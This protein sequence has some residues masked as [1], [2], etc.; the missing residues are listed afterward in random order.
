MYSMTAWTEHVREYAKTHNLSYGCAM[1]E[2][3][4]KASY[5][6]KKPQKLNK[7]ETKENESMGAEE[8]T[9]EV[10]RTLHKKAEHKKKVVGLKAKMTKKQVEKE[11]LEKT[12]SI[13]ENKQMGMEDRDVPAP[14]SRTPVASPAPAS[15]PAKKK[16]GRPK[17]YASAEEAKE[18]KKVKTIESNKRKAQ[19]KKAGK[20]PAPAKKEPNALKFD[21]DY[22]VE[23]L[24]DDKL[25]KVKQLIRK[26]KYV[27]KHFDN[28]Y[29]SNM[30]TNWRRGQKP[31]LATDGEDYGLPDKY[32]IDT[33][34]QVEMERDG[35]GLVDIFK[36]MKEEKLIKYEE[37]HNA[38]ISDIISKEIDRINGTGAP[39]PNPPGNSVMPPPPPTQTPA[40]ALPPRVPPPQPQP[41]EPIP[42][43]RGPPVRRRPTRGQGVRKGGVLEP[44]QKE[45]TVREPIQR[46]IP[47]PPSIAPPQ[48][49]PPPPRVTQRK[50]FVQ[51]GLIAG[52]S[53]EGDNGLTHLYPLSHDN[54]LK[55]LKHLL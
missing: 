8:P 40:P 38:E 34:G 28:H 36:K 21:W 20:A 9:G 39:L 18:A 53:G 41:E 46:P 15:D 22:I 27:G 50:R 35:S 4:C 49:P 45:K 19:E 31:I 47:P 32:L 10:N 1:T 55:M 25:E 6:A 42:P 51:G 54:V 30:L 14:P 24:T 5:K 7:K 23:H 33:G 37:I 12:K 16:A 17:K 44:I 26:N 13:S 29:S 2:P 3:N 43:P 52:Y 48:Q 11:L